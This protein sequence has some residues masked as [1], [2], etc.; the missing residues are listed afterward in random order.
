[1]NTGAAS[2]TA[3]QQGQV[4]ST[5]GAGAGG[6][7]G[8]SGGVGGT[9]MGNVGLGGSIGVVGSGSGSG[10]VAAP[11]AG[12]GYVAGSGGHSPCAASRINAA[13][14]G[15]G[16]A[17]EGA[18]DAGCELIFPVQ[19]FFDANLLGSLRE[20]GLM[21]VCLRR[22]SV[23]STAA[24]V[25]EL[26]FWAGLDGWLVMLG[27]SAYVVSFVVCKRVMVRWYCTTRTHS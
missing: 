15:D 25:L 11:V 9:V 17:L 2:L 16:Q 20:R 21:S 23:M 22:L 6:A 14:I 8:A 7:G 4:A 13:N 18:V 10:H 1:M 24:R 19:R 26:R 27:M 12:S 5:C 3:V